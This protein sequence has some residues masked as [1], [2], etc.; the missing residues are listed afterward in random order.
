MKGNARKVRISNLPKVAGSR[1]KEDPL[2]YKGFWPADRADKPSG[3]ALSEFPNAL[4]KI[5]DLRGMG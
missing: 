2:P 1:S 4:V 5:M 3:G